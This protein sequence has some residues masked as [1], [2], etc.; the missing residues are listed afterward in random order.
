YLQDLSHN[1]ATDEAIKTTIYNISQT[2]KELLDASTIQNEQKQ[3]FI[4]KLKVRQPPKAIFG[5]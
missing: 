4:Y 5:H 3:I 1:F 2:T